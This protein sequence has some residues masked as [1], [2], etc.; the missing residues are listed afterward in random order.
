MEQESPGELSYV[1]SHLL[2]C[3]AV[4]IILPS[5][6]HLSFRKRDQSLIGYGNSMSVTRQVLQHLH[7]S[8]KRRLGINNP[9]ELAKPYPADP[10][11]DWLPPNVSIDR[12]K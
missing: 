3:I 7:W 2:Y 1:E 6:G 11:S 5:E 8:A 4:S 9:L 10:Q 12:E